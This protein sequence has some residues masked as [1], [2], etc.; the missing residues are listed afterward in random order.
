MSG[1]RAVIA[2]FSDIA[3]VNIIVNSTSDTDIRKEA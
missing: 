2:L 1:H 3:V